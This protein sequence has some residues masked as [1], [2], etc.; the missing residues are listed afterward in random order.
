MKHPKQINQH[1]Y[2]GKKCEFIAELYRDYGKERNEG[3]TEY[4]TMRRVPVKW[5]KIKHPKISKTGWIVGF[6]FCFN[7]TLCTDTGLG[8][9]GKYFDPVTRVNYVRV[10]QTPSSKELK[11]MANDLKLI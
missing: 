8:E 4:G 1:N 5:R 6:G 11:I 9:V 3:N 7:G 2:M 10:R